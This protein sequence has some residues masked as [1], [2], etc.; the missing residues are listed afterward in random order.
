MW[1]RVQ[2]LDSSNTLLLL[3]SASCVASSFLLTNIGDLQGFKLH[4]F[5]WQANIC[6]RGDPTAD[7]EFVIE[8][9]GGEEVA[10]FVHGTGE[11]VLCEVIQWC[12]GGDE[13]GVFHLPRP[14]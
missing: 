13:I 8:P 11:F 5:L 4:C 3:V 7:D 9:S 10:S 14:G 1:I 2:W 12:E 6:R